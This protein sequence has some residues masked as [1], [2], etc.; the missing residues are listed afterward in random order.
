MLGGAIGLLAID[1]AQTHNL[2]QRQRY[3][4]QECNDPGFRATPYAPYVCQSEPVYNELNPFLPNHPS[5]GDVDKYFALAIV[6]TAGLSYVLPQKYR[7]YFLGGVIV[8]ES[9]V[10]LHNHSIGLKVSF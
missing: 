10:V 7:R 2:V 9:I 6:G 4:E 1:W 5:T 8:L 3:T